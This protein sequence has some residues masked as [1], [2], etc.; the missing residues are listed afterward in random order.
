MSN[1][2]K[3]HLRFC[4]YSL[5]FKGNTPRT[6]KWFKDDFKWFQKFAQIEKIEQLDKKII[7][8]WIYQGKLL[9]H[10]SAKTIRNRI[11]ALHIFLSWC[12]QENIIR[13]NPCEKIPKPKVPK[14]L[15]KYLTQDQ[16]NRLLDWTKAYPYIYTFERYR[17]VAIISMLIYTG[18]RKAELLNLKLLDV[19]LENKTLFV[20]LGKCSKDRMIPLHHALIDALSEYLRE[21]GKRNANS[22][23][24]FISLR[25]DERLGDT[26][27]RRLVVK[28]HKKSGIHFYPHL[29]RHTFATLMLEGGCNLYAL[30]Q[31]MG[32]SDIKT[33]TIY[34]GASKA[35]LEEQMGMHPINI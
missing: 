13:N 9:H 10:W 25:D 2:N 19:D 31:M 26:A 11:Q 32:H 22:P 14:S 17:A 8:D 23:Y 7:E 16:A 24:F 3:L 35:H 30:S 6:I 15:P 12:V 33:T 5:A 28:L 20:R 21:R 1:I 4:Q 27:I 18:I 34:L 29:L